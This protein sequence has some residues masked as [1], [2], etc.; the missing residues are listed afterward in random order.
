[1]TAPPIEFSAAGFHARELLPPELPQLQALFDANPQYFMLIS[2]A[3]PEPDE[4]QQEF[5][6]RPPDFLA[7]GQR[8]F[9]GFFDA[10]QKLQGLGVVVRDLGVTGVWQLALYFWADAWH[11]SGVPAAMHD[12]LQ[13]WA[14]ARGARWLRLGVVAGNARAERF[15][16]RLGYQEVRRRSGLAVGT[17]THVVRILVKPLHG[18]PVAAYLVRV[19]RDRPDSPLP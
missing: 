2:G 1:M 9:L 16:Q 14:E 15:W 17:R 13:A 6:D 3:P 19:P 11:G 7:H 8:W 18:Q 10:A 4:A 5:D 12:A